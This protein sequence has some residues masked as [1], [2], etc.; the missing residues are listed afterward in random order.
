M[1]R[2]RSKSHSIIELV[3]VLAWV[4]PAALMIMFGWLRLPALAVT[5]PIAYLLARP[6]AGN[7]TWES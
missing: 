5:V 2:G 3:L 1:W 7:A 4:A 6:R